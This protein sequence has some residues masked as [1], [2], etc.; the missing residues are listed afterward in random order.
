LRKFKVHWMMLTTSQQSKKFVDEIIENDIIQ[1]FDL[2]SIEKE[3]YTFQ[4]SGFIWSIQKIFLNGILEITISLSNLNQ[5]CS[6]RIT[7]KEFYRQFIRKQCCV[8]LQGT[9]NG[10]VINRNGFDFISFYIKMPII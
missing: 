8:Y 9:I 6:N 2:K 10:N 5:F 7:N 1:K 4:Q 3:D